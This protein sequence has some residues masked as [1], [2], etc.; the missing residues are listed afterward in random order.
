[1]EYEAL[2]EM[3]VQRELGIKNVAGWLANYLPAVTD[4]NLGGVLVWHDNSGAWQSASVRIGMVRFQ[5]LLGH[6]SV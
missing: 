6:T 3:P 5:R 1:M 4:D 2:L